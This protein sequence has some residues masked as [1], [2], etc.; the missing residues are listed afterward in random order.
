MKTSKSSE[1]SLRGR[2]GWKMRVDIQE[3][4]KIKLKNAESEG[5]ILEGSISHFERLKL[6]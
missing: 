5:R 6:E 4:E 1:K 2:A 3:I